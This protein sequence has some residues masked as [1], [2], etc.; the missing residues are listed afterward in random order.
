MLR[1][2]LANAAVATVVFWAAA[3]SASPL[4]EGVSDTLT[5]A[6][7]NGNIL[8]DANGALAIGSVSEYPLRPQDFSPG[9]VFLVVPITTP[10]IPV[11]G[12]V[13]IL[14]DPGTQNSSDLLVMDPEPD[15][16]GTLF[17]FASYSESNHVLCVD[18]PMDQFKGCLEETGEPQDVTALLFGT[19][20]APFHVIVQSD[21]DDVPE[22]GTAALLGV[23]LA[24]LASRHRRRA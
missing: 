1:P 8:P 3:V 6:D 4:P 15:G 24:A 13:L 20:P 18:P 17:T 19:I 2:H 16:S 9:A 14:T 23:G 10:G 5:I 11:E 21:L 22:P 12:V 7:A